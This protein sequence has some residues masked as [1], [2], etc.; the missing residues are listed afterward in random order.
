MK[1][2]N[3]L[4][5]SWNLKKKGIEFNF[6]KK[7]YIKRWEFWWYCEWINIWNEIS[8]DWEFARPCL[9]LDKWFWNWLILICP[10]T[11]K[12]NRFLKK[13]LFEINNYS[14][15]GLKKKSFL[16][17]NQVKFVD[18]KRFEE[19]ISKRKTRKSFVNNILLNFCNILKPPSLMKDQGS[20]T[21]SFD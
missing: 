3:I 11:S 8:K 20:E 6:Y 7:K 16:I 10:I 12:Y 15:F 19:R 1:K 17:L 4:F 9:V 13:F 5:D 2:T 21:K 14:E 18:K